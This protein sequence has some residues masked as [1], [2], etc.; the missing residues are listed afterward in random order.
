M[1]EVTAGIENFVVE[2]Q[3]EVPFR[4]PNGEVREAVANTDLLYEL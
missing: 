2:C 3:I 4:H 1:G